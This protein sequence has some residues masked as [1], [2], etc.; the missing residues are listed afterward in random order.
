VFTLKLMTYN[1]RGQAAAKRPAHLAGIADVITKVAPDIV[2]L[3]E[4]HCRTRAS[5]DDQGEKLAE[6]TG[7]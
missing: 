5:S 2:G 1:I 3:Q 6:L 7:L 4:V